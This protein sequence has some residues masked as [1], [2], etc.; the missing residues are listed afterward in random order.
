MAA[1][2]P[3]IGPVDPEKESSDRKHTPRRWGHSRSGRRVALDDRARFVPSDK[4]RKLFRFSLVCEGGNEPSREGASSDI[5]P[6]G[7]RALPSVVHA[8]K[9][10][11]PSALHSSMALVRPSNLFESI[12]ARHVPPKPALTQRGGAAIKLNLKGL[13]P[14]RRGGG[15]AT[16]A[17]G[18]ASH[19]SVDSN[20]HTPGSN[21]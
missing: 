14:G 10:R 11:I 2:V 3:E 8:D 9:L 12:H 13:T 1:L 15:R 6:N 21:W 4:P 18:A 7:E 20:A 16:L 17:L 19:S 5:E